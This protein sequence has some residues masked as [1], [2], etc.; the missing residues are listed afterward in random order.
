MR[1]R[2]VSWRNLIPYHGAGILF[3]HEEGHKQ[4][5]VLLGLGTHNPQKKQ[6]SIPAGGWEGEDSYNRNKKRDY[7]ATAIR[8]NWEEIRLKVDK[9]EELTYLLSRHLPFFHFVVYA[10]QLSEKRKVVRYQEFSE[11]KWF[12]VDSLPANSVGFVRSQVAALVRQ[13]HKGEKWYGKIVF[14]R[15]PRKSA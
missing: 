7:K 14:T 6:W 12:P 15:V 10:C 9:P 5:S 3:R 1:H 4:L 13:P 8:E 11:V 2:L